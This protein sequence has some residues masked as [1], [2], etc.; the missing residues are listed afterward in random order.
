VD[1]PGYGYAQISKSE[2]ERF[3]I[4]TEKYLQSGRVSMVVQLIDFRHPPTKDDLQMLSFL[5]QTETPFV[6]ALTKADKLKKMQRQSNFAALQERLPDTKIIQFSAETGE[7]S[8]ELRLVIE[9]HG[10]K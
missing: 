3:G 2:K 4:L 8:E 10:K 7:G 1:L 5:Q 9:E 6:I